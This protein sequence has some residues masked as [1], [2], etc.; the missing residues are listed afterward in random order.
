[1]ASRSID[2]SGGSVPDLASSPLKTGE[3]P[4][5]TRPAPVWRAFAGEPPQTSRPGS[6]VEG[7]DK[8]GTKKK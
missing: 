8:T 6:S 1:M 4:K 2:I 5:T 7:G 3:K